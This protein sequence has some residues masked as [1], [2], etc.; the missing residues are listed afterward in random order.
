MVEVRRV[1][2]HALRASGPC[3]RL[4]LASGVRAANAPPA[5]L[6][7]ALT[8]SEFDSPCE[9]QKQETPPPGWGGVGIDGGGEESLPACASRIRPLRSPSA[10]FGCSG[11]KR[12]TGAFTLRPHS[13]GVRLSMRGP[14]TRNA[15]PVGTALVLMVEV[16]RVELLSTTAHREVSSGLVA[17]LGGVWLGKR[18]T[19]QTPAGPSLFRGMPAASAAAIP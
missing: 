10:R 7:C 12:S 3:A 15:A 5:R 11:C 2:P 9:G 6:L 19:A 1:S 8:L 18:Q 16:R 13:L 14:K 17:F 4:R